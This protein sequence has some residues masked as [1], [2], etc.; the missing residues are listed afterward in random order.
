MKK[1]DAELLE[2]WEQWK[3]A[4]AH[5][6]SA[7]DQRSADRRHAK[8]RQ[9]ERRIGETPAET[10]TGACIKLGMALFIGVHDDISGN[11]VRVAYYDLVRITGIDPRADAKAI[12]GR[13]AA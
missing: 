3:R 11:Q 7:T 5:E 6:L 8:V 2:R 4:L 10:A 13:Q 1:Q 9:I 12:V